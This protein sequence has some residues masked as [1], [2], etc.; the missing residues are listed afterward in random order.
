MHNSRHRVC[1]Q[2]NAFWW[3]S[4]ALPLLF[5]VPGLEEAMLTM[6][7]FALLTRSQ[8]SGEP[9]QHPGAG[10]RVGSKARVGGRKVAAV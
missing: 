1:Y 4:F 10:V 2:G 7:C 6:L 8:K 5:L 3:L 9:V